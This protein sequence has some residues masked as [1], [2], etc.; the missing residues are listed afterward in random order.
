MPIERDTLDYA[1]SLI[2]VLT[3][4]VTG[5][6][7]YFVVTS[8][9]RSS[10]QQR[11]EAGP[12]VRIDVGANAVETDFSPPNVYYR[13]ELHSIDLAPEVGDKEA[14][15]LCAWLRNYQSH[16]LGMAIAVTA[17]FL[18]EVDG[19]EP[20][21]N[22]V[23]IAYLEHEKPVEVDLVRIRR[24]ATAHATLIKLS[25]LDF[26]SHRY[27]HE[28]RGKSTNALLGR[29]QCTYESGQVEA[30]PESRPHGKGVEFEE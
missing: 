23:R 26:Y 3:F 24:D 13:N 22:D 19:A 14:V 27:E 2:E 21:L 18:I 17:S 1:S 4:A 20:V 11:T 30:T 15:T 9:R 29:L 10:E 28:Y 16:P 7:L 6:G 25:F 5:F 8:L 12:Y